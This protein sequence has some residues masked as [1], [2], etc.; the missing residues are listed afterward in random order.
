LSIANGR[1]DAMGT[2]RSRN[3]GAL[4][5]GTLNWPL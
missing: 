4:I 5:G 1:H 3:V 2:S